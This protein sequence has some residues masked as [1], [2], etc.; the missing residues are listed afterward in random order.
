M[1]IS[2]IRPL[3]RLRRYGQSV[4]YDNIRR[5]MLA[6]GELGMLIKQGVLGITSNPTIFEKAIA[7]SEDYDA[8]LRGLARQ[9]AS[10]H[11]TYEALVL[12]DIAAAADQLRPVYERTRGHDGYV[13]IEVRPTLAHDT[14]GTIAEARRLFATLNR[15]NIMIKVPA[16]PE[17]IPAVATLIAD[18]INVNVTLIFSLTAYESVTEA[19]LGGLE[20]RAA[21]GGALDHVA[22]VASFFVSRVDTAVDRQIEAMIAAGRN[23]VKP[24]LGKA[25]IANAKLAYERFERIFGGV[26]FAALRSGGARVQR[27]LWASTGTKNPLYSDVLYV[28]ELIGPDTVNTMPPA[29]LAAFEDHGHPA[30][31]LRKSVRAA[32]QVFADLAAAGI[33][34]GK[35][36]DELLAEGVKAF[37]DSFEKLLANLSS[38]R[39]AL[40]LDGRGRVAALRS[41]EPTLETALSS[42]EQRKLVKRMWARDHTVWK[43]TTTEIS[44]RLGWLTVAAAMQ[45]DSAEVAAF[46]EDVR[47]AGYK[48]VVLLGMGGSSLAPEVL[49]ASFG[50]QVGYPRLHVLDSTVPAWVRRV[51]AAIDPASTLF[52][53]S[54]KSGGTIEVMSFFKHFYALV[55]RVLGATAGDNFI[56]I[57]DPNTGLQ[58]LAEDMH[59][60]RIF[61]N[62]PDIGG[63]YSAL[64]YFGMV[65][66]ALAGIDIDALLRR[67]QDMSAACAPAIPVGE[68]PGAWLGVTLAALAQAG[69]DKVTFI[70]SPRLETFGLWGE[71][72]IAESTGKEGKGLVPVALEPYAPAAAYGSDRVFAYLRLDGDDNA[73]ADAH[74]E[75]LDQAGQPVIR[76]QLR[77]RYDLGAEFFR[78][79]FATALAGAIMGIQPF[80]QPNVQE[81][82]DNT[83]A[84]L[85]RVQSTRQIP[86]MES[87]GS[88]PGLLAQMRPGDYVA[89]MAYVDETPQTAAALQ[90]LRTVIL[91]RYLLPSTLGFGPRF[92]HSTGQLHKGGPNNGL[93]VQLTAAWGDDVTVP[94]ELY[95]FAGLAAA[96]AAGDYASLL[97]HGRRVVRI[98]LGSQV[99]AGIRRLTSHMTDA[100]K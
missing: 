11:D 31:T 81:S 83:A 61:R 66:A 1:A 35:V 48:D 87:T 10:L 49:R 99:A 58:R 74:A 38:K 9:G 46:A 18:G 96:Q 78:W 82:K 94:G 40:L 7:S 73:A 70:T 91:E 55:A 23:D 69:R 97:N 17:G 50:K 71:Q 59:F 72:L 22:S 42:V 24:L 60:R 29:T 56:A 4:W 84:V 19:Y 27:P 45:G 33:D 37:T 67:G 98:N 30:P 14:A 93:F 34:M 36:T 75:A 76:L 80:D 65:P 28:D 62:P 15:P 20:R 44:D 6:S 8:A 47:R 41:A 53:V 3:K 16:T 26:R 79:E 68:N 63:R 39:S 12:A 43:N 21:A 89:L 92:L 5:D 25:A 52:I 51:T 57:T 86:D 90:H 32:H 100:Q 2:M 13:S 85:R 88:L 64:S 54:S 77:D 95:S